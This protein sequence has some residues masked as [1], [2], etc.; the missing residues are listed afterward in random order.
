MTSAA[1]LINYLSKIFPTWVNSCLIWKMHQGKQ[2]GLT[3]C[4]DE[5]ETNKYKLVLCPDSASNDYNEHVRIK[6]Y[7]GNTIVLDHH[8]ADK[9]S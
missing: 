2:H 9:I 1:L 8:L 4:I 3:D 7:G 5:I 6:A